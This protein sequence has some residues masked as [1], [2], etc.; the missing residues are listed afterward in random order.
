MSPRKTSV[1]IQGR[2]NDWAPCF[3]SYKRMKFFASIFLAA[4]TP[5][6]LKLCSVKV[7]CHF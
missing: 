1:E 4:I 5:N 7:K 3:Q 2:L 6:M